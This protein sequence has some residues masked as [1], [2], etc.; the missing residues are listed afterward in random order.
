MDFKLSQQNSSK[1]DFDLTSKMELKS[2]QNSTENSMRQVETEEKYIS[3]YKRRQIS[4]ESSLAYCKRAHPL[5]PWDDI[6]E[7]SKKEAD[8]REG[9]IKAYTGL[10]LDLLERKMS[11]EFDEKLDT[12]FQELET[13]LESQI[14]VKIE[15]I[16]QEMKTFVK[17]EIDEMYEYLYYKNQAILVSSS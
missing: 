2:S 17:N 14:E 8:L 7:L 6:H 11:R 3:R 15:K 16:E 12:K 4:V 10:K 9:Y 13:K 5:F 1:L